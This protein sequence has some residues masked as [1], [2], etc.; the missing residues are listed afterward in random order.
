MRFEILHAMNSQEDNVK[1]VKY[2][3][4]GICCLLVLMVN[5][6]CAEEY[7]ETESLETFIQKS[8]TDEKKEE[9]F[10]EKDDIQ[11]TEVEEVLFETANYG[12]TAK[13]FVYRL[14]KNVLNREPDTAGINDWTN[15]LVTGQM[16]GA[17]VANGFIY[18]IEL[19]NRNLSDSDYVEMLYQTFLN[20][21]ADAS[22]KV[23][24]LSKLEKGMSRSYIYRGFA[25]SKEF[26]QICSKYGIGQGEV[27]LTEPRD[28][29]EGI[30]M[31]VYRC[32]KKALGRVPDVEGL[33]DWC[34]RLINGQE[35]AGQVAYGFIFSSEFKNRNLSNT[36]YAKLLYEVFL[37]RQYDAEGLNMWVDCLEYGMSR[38]KAFLGFVYSTEFNNLC[39]RY[40]IIV[41]NLEPAAEDTPYS[42]GCWV[43]NTYINCSMGLTFSITD[44]WVKNSQYLHGTP[45]PEGLDFQLGCNDTKTIVELRAIDD[46]RTAKEYIEDSRFSVIFYGDYTDLSST[47]IVMV[48]D[49]PFYAYSYIGIMPSG[50]ERA[51]YTAVTEKSGKLL[52]LTGESLFGHWGYDEIFNSFRSIH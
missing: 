52:V 23:D 44:A 15:K 51:F 10:S 47:E 30:T 14:Y 12:N 13:G 27:I 11:I 5:G 21:S 31:F 38:Y 36:D 45:V 49:T 20:R 50:K 16:T 6:V 32:Y 1:T 43:G 8:E 29:N 22:G 26:G 25:N 34:S 7:Q 4:V 18:S 37:D 28:Q 17:E 24:W 35:S 41:G 40:G 48:G 39:S 2:L 9:I 33:N 3:I 46:E 19:A 42:R